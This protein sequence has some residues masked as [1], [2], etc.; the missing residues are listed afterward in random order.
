M[1]AIIRSGRFYFYLL[2]PRSRDAGLER[3]GDLRLERRSALSAASM[4]GEPNSRDR[5]EARG[6]TYQ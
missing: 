6:L 4:G 2:A 5:R 3:Q 1:L